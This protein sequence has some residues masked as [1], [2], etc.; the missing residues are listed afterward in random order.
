LME[1]LRLEKSTFAIFRVMMRNK[2]KNLCAYLGPEL[3]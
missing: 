3:I 1:F 2:E